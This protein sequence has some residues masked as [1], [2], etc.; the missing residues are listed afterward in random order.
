MVLFT[1]GQPD[2]VHR[3]VPVC[4]C[5][6]AFKRSLH[7]HHGAHRISDEQQAEFLCADIC[8]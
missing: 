7:T 3:S 6:A 5:D 8:G 4:A 2:G 1:A